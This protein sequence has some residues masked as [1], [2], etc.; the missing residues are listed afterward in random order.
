MFSRF[1]VYVRQF[2]VNFWILSA[3]WF[4]SALGF[5]LSIPF[6]SIYF[7]AEL[8]LSI[9]EVGLFFGVMAIIRSVFQVVGGEISDRMD[10]RKILIQAQAIRSLAL[11]MLAVSIAMNW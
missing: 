8:G 6:I 2:E 4:V 10:R 1:T 5:A 9:T 11:V 3:G 7:N